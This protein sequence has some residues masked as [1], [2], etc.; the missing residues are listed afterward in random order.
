[1]ASPRRYCGLPLNLPPSSRLFGVDKQSVSTCSCLVSLLLVFVQASSLPQV[2]ALGVKNLPLPGSRRRRPSRV[3]SV[4]VCQRS[5]L[6]L[7]WLGR[8]RRHFPVR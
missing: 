8:W 2:A 3:S 7:R 6:I 5:L 1:M 4:S